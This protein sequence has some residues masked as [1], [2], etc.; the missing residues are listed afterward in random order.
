MKESHLI[1]EI[2]PWRRDSI[3]STSVK[4]KK[5]ITTCTNLKAQ[6]RTTRDASADHCGV[7]DIKELRLVERK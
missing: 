2:P 5:L 4:K 3:D 1:T 6:D 7:S